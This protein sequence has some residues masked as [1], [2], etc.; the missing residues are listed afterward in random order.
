MI[1][2]Y[3][4]LGMAGLLY[5]YL[6]WNFDYWSKLGVS[7]AKTRVLLGSLPNMI[8]RKENLTYDFDR[9]YA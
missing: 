7:S 3:L 9:I 1:F 5:I 6:T 4:L 8:L 2:I